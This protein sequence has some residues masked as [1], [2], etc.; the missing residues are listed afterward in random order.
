MIHEE[1]ERAL[2]RVKHNP[3]VRLAPAHDSERVRR[4]DD[5]HIAIL[6]DDAIAGRQ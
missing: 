5:N 3:H 1:Q 6:S 4:L 2:R